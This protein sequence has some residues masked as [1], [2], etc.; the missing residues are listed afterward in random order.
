MP[1][2]SETFSFRFASWSPKSK[3]GYSFFP[4]AETPLARADRAAQFAQQHRV[5]WRQVAVEGGEDVFLGRP[6]ATGE[7][8]QLVGLL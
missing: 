7:L 2:G 4:L 8:A 6:Q 3:K 1:L 5:A